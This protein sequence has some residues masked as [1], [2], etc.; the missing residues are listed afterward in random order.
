MFA[1]MHVV[2][3]DQL[4]SLHEHVFARAQEAGDDA[5]DMAPAFQH[6]AGDEAH[7]PEVAAAIDETDSRLGKCLAK[8]L[9]RLGK[10]GSAPRAGTAIDAN[11]LKSWL[12]FT[13]GVLAHGVMC[14]RAS[15]GVKQP[16]LV[17][18]LEGAKAIR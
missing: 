2:D 10:G 18:G 17:N 6:R 14:H 13:H 12:D 9:R 3:D 16:C 8:S 4:L 11:S 1:L 5:G 7:Q 15:A